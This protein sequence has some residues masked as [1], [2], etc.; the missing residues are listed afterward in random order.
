M[1]AK[2]IILIPARL[3]SVRLPNKPLARISGEAM[4]THVARRAVEADIA[5]VCVAAGDS[6]IV[7]E[8]QRA[9]FDAVLT[10]SDLPSGSDRCIAALNALAKK[11][12]GSSYDIVINLQGDMPNIEADA[13]RL[14]LAAL[15][16]SDADCATLVHRCSAAQIADENQVKAVLAL[17][18]RVDYPRCLYFSRHALPFGAGV[19]WGHIGIYA[20]RV[21]ALL[22]FASLAPTPLERREKL[23]QLRALENNMVIVA[24]KTKHPPISVDSPEDLERARKEMEG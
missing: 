21:A 18:E 24:A 10:D 16:A 3:R 23:E 1:V 13:L 15:E 20:W 11:A 2:A 5:P 7:D 19:V 4:I 6:E 9:G 22:E 12:E 17:D 8:V 14:V